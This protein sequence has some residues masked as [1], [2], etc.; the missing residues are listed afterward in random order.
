MGWHVRRPRYVFFLLPSSFLFAGQLLSP[1]SSLLSVEVIRTQDPFI[2]VVASASV[3]AFHHRPATSDQPRRDSR[4]LFLQDVLRILS[5][6]VSRHEIIGNVRRLE[7]L[8]STEEKRNIYRHGWWK[9]ISSSRVPTSR[10]VCAAHLRLFLR[11]A[12]LTS[13]SLSSLFPLPFKEVVDVASPDVHSVSSSGAHTALGMA[14]SQPTRRGAAFSNSNPKRSVVSSTSTPN[15]Q[16]ST[17]FPFPGR[18]W[19]YLSPAAARRL[20]IVPSTSESPLHVVCRRK[21]P[22]SPSRHTTHL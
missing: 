7:R 21:R 6:S 16:R 13:L 18:F 8:K 22:L 3:T 11:T 4:L 17:L 5:V 2:I 10:S 1:S 14:S 15:A 20:L 19:L 12:R 9:M